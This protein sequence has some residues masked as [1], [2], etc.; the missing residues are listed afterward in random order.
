MDRLH[1]LDAEFLYLEDPSSPMHIAGICVFEGPMPSR[2]ALLELYQAKLAQ[3]P[4][5]RQRVRAVPWDL[6]RPVWVDDPHFDVAHHIRFT[7]LPQP[8]DERDLR[9]LMGRLMSQLLD[10]ER[11][12]WESWFVEGLADGRWALI[13]KVHHAMVDGVSGT[14][15]LTALLEERPD[16]PMPFVPVWQPQPEPSRSTLLREALR[17]LP[18]DA[19]SWTRR[20]AEELRDPS[21]A[22][23]RTRDLALGAARMMRSLRPTA[24]SSL[25]GTVGLHRSYAFACSPLADLQLIRKAYGGTLNDVVLAI[26]SGAYRALLAHHGDDVSRGPIRSLVPVS[27]RHAGD[28]ALDN[29]V[30]ALLCD[31][32]VHLSDPLERLHAISANMTE[33]KSS[34]MAEASAF[35]ATL[36]DLTPPFLLGSI[37]RRVARSM[38]KSPQQ[39]VTTVTTHVPGPRNTLFLLGRPLSH[40]Y[41]YVPIAQGTRLGTAVLTY[42]GEVAYGVTA[43]PEHVPDIDLFTHTIA[44]DTHTLVQRARESLPKDTPPEHGTDERLS[45]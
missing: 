41:P 33:L 38:H 26:L 27:V 40:Y 23:S 22:A 14:G 35:L 18:S 11:P 30:A 21:R 15:L 12:L 5:Y 9:A 37:M 31:L 39:T 24:A 17:E 32:P 20:V 8:G 10:R 25:K 44:A 19:R 13:S 45:I 16:A 6:A 43:D 1:S 28:P 7:A 42:A 34:H 4:R 36:G 3:Y 29:R 2:A